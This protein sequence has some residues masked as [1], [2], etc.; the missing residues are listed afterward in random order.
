MNS[1]T[2]LYNYL[3]NN[4]DKK[5][6]DDNNSDNDLSADTNTITMTSSTSSDSAI[7]SDD[8]DDIDLINDKQQ[9]SWPDMFQEAQS[10]LMNFSQSFNLLQQYKHQSIYDNEI[11]I[12]KYKQP[13]PWKNSTY[14][15]HIYSDKD[16]VTLVRELAQLREQLTEKEDE[17]T[18]LK[19]E[20]NNTRVNK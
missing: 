5:D 4:F 9:Y 16:Y 11:V 17:V 12:S 14:Y 20:R 10:A 1:S 18:E 7:A 8:I 6:D 2:N 15:N 13:L 3:I 19:A